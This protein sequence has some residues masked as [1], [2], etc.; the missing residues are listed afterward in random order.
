MAAVVESAAAGAQLVL[1]AVLVVVAVRAARRTGSPRLGLLALA[2]TGFLAQGL[3]LAY[4]L[5][6]VRLDLGTAVATALALNAA[7]LCLVY[8]GVLRP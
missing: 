8:V 5:L 1:A 6:T 3:V 2:F 4:A 7:A